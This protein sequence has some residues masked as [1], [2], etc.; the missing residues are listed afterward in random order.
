MPK[1]TTN[2]QIIAAGNATELVKIKIQ[3]VSGVDEPANLTPGWAML[4][5]AGSLA[6]E[7]AAGEREMVPLATADRRVTMTPGAMPK[8]EF[9][10]N[11]GS[12]LQKAALAERVVRSHHDAIATGRLN[13]VAAAANRR[14]HVREHLAKAHE[15]AGTPMPE[16]TDADLDAAITAQFEGQGNGRRARGWL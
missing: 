14:S 1:H 5:S 10:G 16:Y 15:L 7:H 3:E 4:K 12:R 8:V 13:F 9:E 2:E 6:A 11:E